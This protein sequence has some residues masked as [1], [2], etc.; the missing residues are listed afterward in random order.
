MDIQSFKEKYVNL[1]YI[2][3]AISFLVPLIVYLDTVAPTVSFWDC[4]EF[5]GCSYTMG[6]PHP[7][8]APLYLL[9]GRLFSLLPFASDIAFRVNLVS[10][11]SSVF[12]VLLLYLTTVRLIK[13]WWEEES[14]IIYFAACLGALSFTFS[15]TFW[16]N[17]VESEVYAMS[18]FLTALVLY[19]A[20]IWMDN[21][22]KFQSTRFLIFIV[23]I[24]GIGFGLHLLNLLVVPSVILLILFTELKV[25]GNYKLWLISLIM[26]AAGISIYLIVYIRSGKDP[27]FDLN[28][29]ENFT[30][31]IKYLKREQYGTQSLFLT[32]FDRVAPFWEYQIKKMNLRYFGWNFIGEGV[33]PGIDRGAAEII[34]FRGLYGLPFLLG[35]IGMVHHFKSDWRRALS[36]LTMFIMTGIAITIYLNQP[37]PQPRERDYVYVGS[38]FAF[39]IWIGIGMQAIFE[40]IKNSLSNFQN[41]LRPALI[42]ASAVVLIAVPLNM[43]RFNYNSQDRSGNTAAWDFAY[44]ILQN[45]EEN[46]LLFVGGDNDTYP[47]WYLQ[48]VERIRPDV[49]VLCFPLMNSDWF[50]LQMKQ[51]MNV[52]MR[53]PDEQIKKFAPVLWEETK[54]VVM[55]IHKSLADRYCG[56]ELKN[57]KLNE[58][59][60]IVMSFDLE[61]K[62]MGR[63]LRFQDYVALDVIFSNGWRYPV[64]FATTCPDGFTLNMKKFF[65]MDGL[66]YK[67][68]PYENPKIDIEKLH[69]YI[70]NVMRFSNFDDPQIYFNN[71]TQGY[72]L[73][74]RNAFLQL[75]GAYYNKGQKDQALK[76]LEKMEKEIPERVIPVRIRAT[77]EQIAQLYYH[78]GSH[79]EFRKRIEWLMEDYSL[80]ENQLNTYGSWYVQLLKDYEK[81]KEVFADLYNKNPKNGQYAGMLVLVYEKL[82][83]YDK[84]IEILDSWIQ[85]HPNQKDAVNKRNELLKLKE[86]SENQ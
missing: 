82:K 32:V 11:L 80:S 21:H 48:T 49:R 55:E 45:C 59:G 9:I 27:F 81:G 25:L 77:S 85:M 74:Y 52:P 26:I 10:V 34:S 56:T 78:L 43:A 65:R 36:V 47:V 75:C 13:R 38:Y 40:L 57:V 60:N 33:I 50:P 24:L 73:N 29:P 17:A 66:V 6:V 67:L 42:V 83:M 16:F 12:T 84:A 61:P 69:N 28:N 86:K 19:L 4:G 8:G 54:P 39:A 63:F 5:I 58:R 53:M 72:L 46:A 37:D 15:D 23:Y 20:I 68:M 71:M 35:L 62:F 31:L 76:V 18:M 7:P 41:Y 79:D 3:G 1:F 30:N 22:E 64:Y 44:N 70:F 51:Q 14:F 2:F